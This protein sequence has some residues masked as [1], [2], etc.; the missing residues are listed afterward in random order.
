MKRVEE[1]AAG[2]W[3]ELFQS[4]N[5]E[6]NQK[7]KAILYKFFDKLFDQGS[8]EEAIKSDFT[9]EEEKRLVALLK[10]ISDGFQAPDKDDSHTEK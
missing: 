10:R 8:N 5:E 2:T 4:A 1:R 6:E 9:E 7:E 3:Q